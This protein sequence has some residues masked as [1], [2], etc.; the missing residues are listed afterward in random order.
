MTAN[1]ELVESTL[2][3]YMSSQR[4]RN[5]LLPNNERKKQTNVFVK[6]LYL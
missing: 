3:A 2:V 5:V 6:Q 1:K 4:R